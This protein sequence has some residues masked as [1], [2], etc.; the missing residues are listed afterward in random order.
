MRFSKKCFDD[1][2]DSAAAYIIAGIGLAVLTGLILRGILC[3]INYGC[4]SSKT[5]SNQQKPVQTSVMYNPRNSTNS[6]TTADFFAVQNILS[7][8]TR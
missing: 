7:Q 1:K 6:K 5:N 8:K 3:L 2:K 4:D